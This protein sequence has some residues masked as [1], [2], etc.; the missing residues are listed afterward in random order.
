M[1]FG[2]MDCTSEFS[3]FSVP[4]IQVKFFLL[5]QSMSKRIYNFIAVV[6]TIANTC[7]C[8]NK[9]TKKD[10]KNLCKKCRSLLFLHMS[11]LCRE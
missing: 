4:V 7:L 10:E 6:V 11:L 5:G 1:V 9:A 3:D 2:Y 8:T